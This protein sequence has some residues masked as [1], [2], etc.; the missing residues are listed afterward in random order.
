[1]HFSRQLGHCV[2]E[3]T[4]HSIKKPTY[5]DELKKMKA[6]SSKCLDYFHAGNK[7]GPFYLV[8]KLTMWFKH[9]LGW[10]IYEQG[11]LVLS[12]IVIGAAEELWLHMIRQ[13]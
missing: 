8:T 7:T 11:D 2:C 6:C 4:I 1:M 12:Q 13:N 5:L 10:Y 9:K 3:S